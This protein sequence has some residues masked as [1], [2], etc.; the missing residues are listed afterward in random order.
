VH[1]AFDAWNFRDV[2]GYTAFAGNGYIGETIEIQ[3][4]FG[5]PE[6]PDEP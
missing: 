3:R 5:G 4:G 6:T 2:D 1:K